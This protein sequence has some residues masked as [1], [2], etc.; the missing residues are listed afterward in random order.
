MC[1][2]P[3]KKAVRVASRRVVHLQAF[4]FVRCQSAIEPVVE[5]DLAH[6]VAALRGLDVGTPVPLLELAGEL[7]IHPVARLPQTH[8][9]TPRVRSL[10]VVVVVPLADDQ[11]ATRWQ[12]LSNTLQEGCGMPILV[13]QSMIAF[14]GMHGGCGG[15]EHVATMHEVSE[16]RSIC[17]R[18][19]YPLMRL[20][21]GVWGV[22]ARNSSN[23]RNLVA[24]FNISISVGL[25]RF[26][27]SESWSS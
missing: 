1:V 10:D 27:S 22:G 18:F 17:Y 15:V 19:Q 8:G 23:F 6:L 2:T 5:H 13:H 26:S 20:T 7:R 3:H 24:H 11:P 25:H 16:T 14:V 9:Y 4:E 21:W 12:S